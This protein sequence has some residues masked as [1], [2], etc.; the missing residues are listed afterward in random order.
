MTSGGKIGIAS[1]IGGEDSLATLRAGQR[2]A[3]TQARHYTPEARRTAAD[4]EHF[5][6]ATLGPAVA[7]LAVSGTNRPASWAALT[8]VFSLSTLKT[9][10]SSLDSR[11]SGLRH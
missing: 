10:R 6:A 9:R 3:Q 4:R 8:P 1:R 7:R 5:H 2:M 11:S